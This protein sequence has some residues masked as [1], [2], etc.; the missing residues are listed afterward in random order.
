MHDDPPVAPLFSPPDNN[1][2]QV[3]FQFGKFLP[4]LPCKYA[5]ASQACKSVYE[6]YP[7]SRKILAC[8]GHLCGLVKTCP[9]LHLDGA[10]CGG[11]YVLSVNQ[12]LFLSGFVQI[13]LWSYS[14]LESSS[15]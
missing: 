1:L 7:S 4:S 9:Y 8:H 6:G 2:V 11:T 3:T 15:W 10:A 12:T 14:Y 5:T 13:I